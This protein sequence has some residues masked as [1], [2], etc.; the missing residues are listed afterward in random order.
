MGPNGHTGILQVRIQGDTAHVDDIFDIAGGRNFLGPRNVR[1]LLQQLVADNP[2]VKR[3]AGERVS[4]AR[5]GGQTVEPGAGVNVAVNA[6]KGL[7]GGLLGGGLLS[8]GNA[9]AAQPPP[10]QQPNPLADIMRMLGQ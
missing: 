10:Y 5:F 8:A 9:E 4:G 1:G 7:L 6:R 3:V 2:G